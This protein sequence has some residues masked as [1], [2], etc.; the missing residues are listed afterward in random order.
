MFAAVYFLT[1]DMTPTHPSDADSGLSCG[2]NCSSSPSWDQGGSAHVPGSLALTSDIALD[3][4]SWVQV[5]DAAGRVRRAVFVGEQ[6][7]PAELEWDAHDAHAIHAVLRL[8]SGEPLA[9]GRLVDGAAL[10]MPG[11]AKIGRMAVMSPW[12]G[13]GLGSGLLRTLVAEARGRGFLRVLLHA[14]LSAAGFYSRAGF[15]RH[16]DVFTEVNVPH[17]EMTL[18]L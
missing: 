17:V 16:G 13:R 11:V 3:V 14:Q 8:S 15:E 12:R 6:G 18:K 4:G 10:G 5:G 9:T 7:I 1:N 2:L